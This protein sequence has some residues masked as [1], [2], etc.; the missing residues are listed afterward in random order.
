MSRAGGAAEA[1]ENLSRPFGALETNHVFSR[2][3]GGQ[4]R[5]FQF[6]SRRAAPLGLGFLGPASP[7]PNDLPPP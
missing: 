1:S 5:L 3:F 4:R 2:A 7:T 6:S